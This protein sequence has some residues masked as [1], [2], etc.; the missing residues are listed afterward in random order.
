M[1]LPQG[2]LA[3]VNQIEAYM[4]ITLSTETKQTVLPLY[5]GSATS[6]AV[7]DAIDEIGSSRI[8]TY[9]PDTITSGQKTTIG[10]DKIATDWYAA[11]IR[12]DSTVFHDGSVGKVIFV[13]G[14]IYHFPS[15]T[16]FEDVVDLCHLRM[17]YLYVDDEGTTTQKTAALSAYQTALN[18]LS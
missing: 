12:G 4:S 14:D 16:D 15:T 10:V 6:Y 18:N 9:D 7:D 3:V 5:Y 2:D 11:C 17:S 1:A 8:V 13:S